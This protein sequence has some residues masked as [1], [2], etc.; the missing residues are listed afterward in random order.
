MK[1]S[2][3]EPGDLCLVRQK[4]FG[5]KHKISD[6][7]ENTKYVVVEQQLNPLLYIIKPWQGGGINLGSPQKLAYAHSTSPPTV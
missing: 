4:V 5:G 6:H 2:R 3:L 1:A 7:W